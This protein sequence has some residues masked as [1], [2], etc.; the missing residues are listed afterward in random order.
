[1]LLRF[2]A[3]AQLFPLSG[4]AFLHAAAY[5][6]EQAEQRRGI[7]AHALY[8]AQFLLRR[9]QHRVKAAETL[10]QRV[11]QRIDIALGD[12]V[13]QHQ[14]QRFVV[15]KAVQALSAEPFP[16]P[17]AVPVMRSGHDLLP[18]TLWRPWYSFSIP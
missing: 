10:Q 13:K 9:F 18:P 5:G 15:G 8:P 6:G 7:L 14:L 11:G 2:H 1:M 16:H 12:G 17:A 3:V 4:A